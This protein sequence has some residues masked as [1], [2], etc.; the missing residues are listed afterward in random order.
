M[1]KQRWGGDGHLALMVDTVAD[2]QTDGGA[3][4]FPLYVHDTVEGGGKL[5]PGDSSASDDGPLFTG[6]DGPLFAGAAA[7]AGAAAPRSQ[8]PQRRDGITDAGLAHVRAAYP[9][10]VI[11]KEDIFY[12][13]YG[14]L[15]APEYRERYA[16]NLGKG[17]PRMPRVKHAVD[18]WA[19]SQAGR[20]LADLHTGFE[21]VAEYPATIDGPARPTAAQLRVEKMKLGKGKDRS[22]I[23]YNPFITVR[24]IPLEAWDYVVNGK[25][26][27][28]WVMDRQRV[29]TDKASGIVHDPNDWATETMG[30]PR[31]PLSL[32][33]RVITVSLE[34]VRIVASLPPLLI[35]GDDDPS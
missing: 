15:H 6:P 30:D 8:A 21:Q 10:E 3:Q 33:L 1:V 24:D 23:H 26:A 29:R 9:G 18:F 17:L 12:Y 31:Y 19:F 4:F 25:P 14:L 34:T 16:D 27:I 2:L 20:D 11:T 28:G 7:Q 32:L 35:E 13:V 22:V 5:S